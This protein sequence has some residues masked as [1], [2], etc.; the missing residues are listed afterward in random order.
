MN[1]HLIT[2]AVT[3]LGLLGILAGFILYRQVAG[4]Q[5]AVV[6]EW[7]RREAA[8]AR[9]YREL[10]ECANDAILVHD[11]ESGIIL[12]CNRKACEMYGW[13]RHALVGSSLKSLTKDVGRYAEETRRVQEGESCAGFT[14]VHSCK[15]GRALE[16]L[17]SLSNVEYAGKAAVLSFNR[18]VTERGRA[19]EKLKRYTADLEAAKIVQEK[20]TEELARLVEELA[21]ERDLLGSLMDNLPDHIYFKDR[22]SRFTRIN[23]AH[24]R[25]FGLADPTCAIGKSDFD[26]FTDEH[27]QQAFADEQEITRT[28]QPILGKE[29]KETWPDRHVTWVSTTKMPLLDAHGSIIGTFG[30]SRDITRRRQA[31]ESLREVSQRLQLALKSAKAATWSW[32]NIDG[33]LYWDNYIWPLYGRE[34]KPLPAS[35]EDF[36]AA[37]HPDDREQVKDL[38]NR[39][40]QEGIPHYSE[41]RVIWPEGS[42]HV[43]ANRGDVCRNEKGTVSQM[44]GVTWDITERKRAE[45]KLK[46]YASELEAAR[47]VQEQNTRELTKAFEEL[48]AAKVRAEAASQAKSEFLANMSHEIRT[49]LNGI[50]GMSELLLDTPLSTEQSEYLTMLKFSTEALL[51]LVNDILD[52]SKVEARKITLDAIEF[53]LA[54]SLGDTLKSLAARAYQKGLELACSI[55]P[56][57]PEYL[58]GDPGRLRQIILNL[59]GNAIKFTEKGEV[60]VQ[61]EVDSQ[62]EEHVTLHFTVRD[63][64]IGIPPGKQQVIFGPFEQA[65]ASTTRRYGGS[66]LGLAITSHLVKL[67]GGGIWVESA[68]GQGSTFHFTARF[69]LGRSAGT[70]RWAEFARLRN[71]PALVV[72]DNSTNRHILVEVLRRWKMIPIEAEG[73]QRALDLLEQSKRARNPYAAILLDSQMQDIDGF[74][75]AE[76]VK[77]DPELAGAVIL[78]LTSGGRPGDAARCRQLGIAAYLMKPVKQSEILEAILLAFGT[79]AGPSSQPLVTRHFLREERR[80]LHILLAEDNPVN[81]ALVMRLLEKR[82]HTVEVAANGKQAL[83]ALE[84]TSTPRFDLILMD[85]LMPEM[86]GEECVARIRARENGS[87]ARIPIIALTAHAMKGD[88]ERILAIGVD[89]YLP[90]PVRAQQLFET[91]EGLLQVPAGLAAGHPPDSHLENVLDRHQVLARFEGDRLLLGNLISAFFNDCPKLVSAARDAAARQNAV[92]FQRVTQVLKHHLALFSARAAWE[93]ADLAELAGRPQSQVHIGEALD[94]LEEELERLLPALANFGKEVTP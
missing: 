58:I 11:R 19:E 46:L 16:V 78:M 70:A 49:P 82:G 47:D 26:F 91:I 57:V 37:I 89:G 14:T 51:V 33:T 45:E 41:F 7:L 44:T 24:A 75:V 23:K 9:Q 71:L 22:A 60:V 90:K 43:L 50:L 94:R 31:E 68:P 83:E 42:M 39:S 63:T 85:M 40:V 73:G 92:E 13:N 59:V 25:Q 6:R 69:G 86:D 52:F 87:S 32:D 93:A 29:E 18:D 72:D 34:P 88:R 81:Q 27:A 17:V 38:L 53:K 3:I 28:G 20:H 8:L 67:M 54:E 66:G 65:D 48:G 30:V 84:R 5:V 80:R 36:H 64:G 2:L 76:F 77:R 4:G 21:R 35:Y 61:V 10:F 15:D 12:D 1:A 56:Q 62:S 74:A 79:P 55:A